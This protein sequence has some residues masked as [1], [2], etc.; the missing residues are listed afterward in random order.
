MSY[1][2][3]GELIMVDKITNTLDKIKKENEAEAA[4]KDRRRKEIG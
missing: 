3:C 4:K 1:M 2:K